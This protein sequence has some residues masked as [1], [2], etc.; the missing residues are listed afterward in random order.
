MCR[1]E[2]REDLSGDRLEVD[3]AISCF[4]ARA[5]MLIW[6]WLVLELMFGDLE[7]FVRDS[8]E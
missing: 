2:A 6:P 3:V 7:K 8:W 5:H 1:R 4:S